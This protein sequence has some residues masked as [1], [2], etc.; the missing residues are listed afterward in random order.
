MTGQGLSVTKKMG[1]PRKAPT[2]VVRLPLEIIEKAERWA[3]AQEWE[4]SR[5]EAICRLVQD[6]LERSAREE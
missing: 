2:A 3:E 6:G 1:R 4:L 5:A